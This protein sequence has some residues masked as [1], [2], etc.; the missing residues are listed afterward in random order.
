MTNTE[1]QGGGITTP[2]PTL[3]EGIR[4]LQAC[5]PTATNLPP[6]TNKHQKLPFPCYPG[7]HEQ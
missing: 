4:V 3:V 7:G 2:S 1:Q 5:P 6:S